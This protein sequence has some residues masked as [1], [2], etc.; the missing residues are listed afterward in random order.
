MAV[1]VVD[2]VDAA[3]GFDPVVCV[4]ETRI[5]ADDGD[6][7]VGGGSDIAGV[8]E[9]EIE[10]GAKIFAALGVE[11]GGASVTINR[12]A[13]EAMV[14]A[15]LDADG[16]RA[17]PSD[18]ELFD[19]FAVRVI[20]DLAFAAVVF[21]GGVGVVRFDAAI[22]FFCGAKDGFS[23]GGGGE[24]ALLLVPRAFF[25]SGCR[26]GFDWFFEGGSVLLFGKGFGW[27][28]EWVFDRLIGAGEGVEL[29]GDEGGFGVRRQMGEAGCHV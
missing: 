21:E 12:R 1:D 2:D 23:A 28:F 29:S 11:S 14:G 25:G 26:Q 7:A 20:A 16:A 24:L 22:W 17:V 5:G 18:E 27:W 19:G 13:V 10:D 15:E 8:F 4:G 9:D 3:L 6:D